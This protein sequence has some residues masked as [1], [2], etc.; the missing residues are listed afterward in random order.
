LT[1]GQSYSLYLS[2]CWKADS[3]LGV[4]FT[5]PVS[6]GTVRSPC[7][8]SIEVGLD[9]KVVRVDRHRTPPHSG[10]FE[11]NGLPVPVCSGRGR[12]RSRPH[13]CCPDADRPYCN[14]H[15]RDQ[16]DQPWAMPPVS[17]RHREQGGPSRPKHDGAP[18]GRQESCEQ[19]R[20]SDQCVDDE[21]D[22]RARMYP[23]S[24]AGDA[25]FEVPVVGGPL[26]DC[27]PGG[28]TGDVAASAS[29][30]G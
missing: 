13:S 30:R 21:A 7:V 29:A 12:G 9:V 1:K 8:D 17:D 5:V 24:G 22:R 3:T 26:G 20:N 14:R 27:G 19:V 16:G 4:E 2:D 6:P 28:N 11:T 15:E 23:P 10:D 18:E 25:H